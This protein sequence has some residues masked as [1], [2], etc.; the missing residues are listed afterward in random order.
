MQGQRPCWGSKGQRPLSPGKVVCYYACHLETRIAGVF[1]H[2]DGLCVHGRVP[3]SVLG[4]V[5]FADYAGAVVGLADVRGAD[6]LPVYSLSAALC[7]N[8]CHHRMIWYSQDGG[9]AFEETHIL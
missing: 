5:L 2:A 7:F 3:A 1:S 8:E 9:G 4:D 6:E